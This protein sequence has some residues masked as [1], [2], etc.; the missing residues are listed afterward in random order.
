MA[1]TS[2]EFSKNALN[3]YEA[4]FES[5]GAVVIQMKRAGNGYLN[6]YANLDGMDKKY[7]GG[8]NDYNGADNL[9]FTVDVPSGVTVTIESPVEVES[10]KVLSNG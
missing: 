2:L 4:S 10:A 9:I 8:L 1:A 6:V 3:R 5:E 7:I